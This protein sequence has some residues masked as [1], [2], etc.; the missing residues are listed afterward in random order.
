MKG[1]AGPVDQYGMLDVSIELVLSQKNAVE[2]V[3]NGGGLNHY[4]STSFSQS[5]KKFG[6]ASLKLVSLRKNASISSCEYSS[7]WPV[8]SAA[9]A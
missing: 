5:L 6:V 9:N 2:E 4:D 7:L 1:E 3:V 8:Y